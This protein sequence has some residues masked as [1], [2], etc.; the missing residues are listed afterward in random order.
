MKVIVTIHFT[1][2]GDLRIFAPVFNE[3]RLHKQ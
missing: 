2:K 1:D 3:Q